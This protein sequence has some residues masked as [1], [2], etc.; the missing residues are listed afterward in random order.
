MLQEADDLP[1]GVADWYRY[2]HPPHVDYV[3]WID[4]QVVGIL[5]GTFGNDFSGNEAF[6]SLPLPRA[7]HAFLTRVYVQQHQRRGR[8]GLD[9]VR[10]FAEDA[11]AGRSTYIAGTFDRTSDVRVRRRF[12]E[13]VGFETTRDD[14]FGADPNDV[15]DTIARLD[16]KTTS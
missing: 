3:A 6:A 11:D 10:A 4:D 16:R 5:S 13:T 15:L 7:P 14:R 8:I 1:V 12:F 9:L 2:P